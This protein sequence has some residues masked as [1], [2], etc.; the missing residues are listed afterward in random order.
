MKLQTLMIVRFW[1]RDDIGWFMHEEIPG[2]EDARAKH[3]NITNRMFV[4][5]YLNWDGYKIRF[6][7]I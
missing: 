3:R 7:K 4:Q 2:M 6:A 5:F 1:K